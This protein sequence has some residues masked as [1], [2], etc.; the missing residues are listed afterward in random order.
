MGFWTSW[1]SHKRSK[2]HRLV[3]LKFLRNLQGH[4]LNPRK[5]PAWFLQAGAKRPQKSLR[6]LT[7]VRAAASRVQEE[8]L[9]L[10]IP[11]NP[12]FSYETTIQGIGL[13][14]DVTAA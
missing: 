10:P 7:Y 12:L 9:P 8:G 13:T 1:D 3:A 2:R 11:K 4:F 5:I 14:F 6:H